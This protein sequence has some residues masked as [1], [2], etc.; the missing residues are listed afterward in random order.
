LKV[1]WKVIDWE[2]EVDVFD[3]GE[4]SE[5]WREMVYWMIEAESKR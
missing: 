5:R 1:R 4:G 2:V 3:E